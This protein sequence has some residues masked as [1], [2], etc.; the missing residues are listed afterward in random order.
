ML[1]YSIV[2]HSTAQNSKALYST[3][4]YYGMVWCGTV[5]YYGMVWYGIVL[6]ITAQHIIIAQHIVQYHNTV[7]YSVSGYSVAQCYHQSILLAIV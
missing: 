6:H 7:Q 1:M 5:R 2:Y 4:Q 3:A